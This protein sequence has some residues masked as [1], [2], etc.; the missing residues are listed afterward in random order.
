[1]NL[2]AMLVLSVPLGLLV[3]DRRT[4]YLVLVGVFLFIYPFQT[5]EVYD[6]NPANMTWQYPLVNLAILLVGLGLTTLGARWQRRRSAPA[7]HRAS[8]TSI[9]QCNCADS[10]ATASASRCAPAGRALM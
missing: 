2:I 7:G 9:P 3:R 8:S 10:D 1:M 5:V 4:A 6:T